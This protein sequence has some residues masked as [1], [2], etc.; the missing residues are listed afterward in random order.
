MEVKQWLRA[1]NASYSGGGDLEDCGSKISW[2]KSQ[3][4]PISTKKLGVVVSA[5]ILA[6]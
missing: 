4:D 6:T 3:Q 5:V 1:Y 2:A